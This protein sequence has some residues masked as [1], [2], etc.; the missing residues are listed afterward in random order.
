MQTL[1]MQVFKMGTYQ[2]F[3]FC[4]VDVEHG[5]A[6]LKIFSNA[7]LD[8]CEFATA[9]LGKCPSPSQEQKVHKPRT[10]CH[11]KLEGRKCL[12]TTSGTSKELGSQLKEVLTVKEETTD[13]VK[14]WRS[15]EALKALIGHLLEVFSPYLGVLNFYFT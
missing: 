15:D 12:T 7:S 10:F 8:C 4:P 5:C 11:T 9:P 14:P 3:I 1:K 2:Q 6:S 13:V